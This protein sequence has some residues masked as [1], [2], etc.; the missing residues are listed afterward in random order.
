MLLSQLF[1]Q[2][3]FIY[4]ECLVCL[5]ITVIVGISELNANSIDADQTPR[6]AAFD[7]GLHRLPVSLLW[8][9]RH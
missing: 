2:V 8:G 9:A 6:S 4:T 7:L 1:G 3:H 5:I